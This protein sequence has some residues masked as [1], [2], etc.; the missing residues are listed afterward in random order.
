[1]PF[2]KKKPELTPVQKLL[3]VRAKNDD[4]LAISRTKAENRLMKERDKI[5]NNLAEKRVEYDSKK[6]K[7]VADEQIAEIRSK[8]DEEVAKI[9]FK[10]DQEIVR[11]NSKTNQE[12]ARIR[13]ITD[14]KI[15]EMNAIGDEKIAMNILQRDET[16]ALNNLQRD[17]AIALN[18]IASNETLTLIGIERAKIQSEIAEIDT[19]NSDVLNNFKDEIKNIMSD[20]RNRRRQIISDAVLE[21]RGIDKDCTI[22]IP[23]TI[24]SGAE[25]AFNIEVT[26]ENALELGEMCGKIKEH[27]ILLTTQFEK[28]LKSMQTEI[29][30]DITKETLEFLEISF[31][32]LL[33]DGAFKLI[34]HGQSIF[35]LLDALSILIEELP[36]EFKKKLEI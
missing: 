28:Q 13:G 26:K 4:D 6:R 24:P 31:G 10:T 23:F 35:T 14:S 5:E 22:R 29:D 7:E 17:E 34:Y 16:V 30:E 21:S 2:F 19:H 25:V 27:S 11:I 3:Q 1:M 12:V 15:N 8:T 9:R 36:K 20:G 33:G 18:N 32:A